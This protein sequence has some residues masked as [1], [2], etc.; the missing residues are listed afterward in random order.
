MTSD[1]LLVLLLTRLVVV[2]VVVLNVLT[3]NAAPPATAMVAIKTTTVAIL[4]M[5]LFKRACTA[6]FSRSF[7]LLPF[8]HYIATIVSPQQSD[9]LPI[10]VRRI[11]RKE[12]LKTLYEIFLFLNAEP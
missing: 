2:V 10:S 11:I 6:S 12:Y 8:S 5:A 4:P 9:R 1:T 3:T 7:C